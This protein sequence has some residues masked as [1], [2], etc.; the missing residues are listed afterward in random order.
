MADR[1]IPRPPL[2]GTQI[3]RKQKKAFRLEGALALTHVRLLDG[4]LHFNVQVVWDD[5]IGSG[6][7]EQ[8][9]NSLH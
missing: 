5:P 4:T 3:L 8:G 2:L 9:Y 1:L 7:T 6:L